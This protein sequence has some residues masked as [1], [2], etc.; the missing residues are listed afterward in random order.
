[1]S[2]RARLKKEKRRS[3]LHRLYEIRVKKKS[4]FTTTI[5]FVFRTRLL[6]YNIITRMD[7]H[8]ITA[9]RREIILCTHQIPM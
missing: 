7:K 8:T 5:L 3:V 4:T 1:M 2:G 9:T 6:F